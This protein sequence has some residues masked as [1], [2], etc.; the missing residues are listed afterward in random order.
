MLCVRITSPGPSF[1]VAQFGLERRSVKP[2]VAG[3]NPV[4]GGSAGMV[5][6]CKTLH[7]LWRDRR[8]TR[9]ASKRLTVWSNGNDTRLSPWRCGFN[10]Y[11]RCCSI[12]QTMKLGLLLTWKVILVGAKVC[13][14]NSSSIQL[15]VRLSCL[16]LPCGVTVALQPPNLEIRVQLPA[17]DTVVGC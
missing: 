2:Q 15:G 9:R 16:P 5:Q 6:R 17:R 7:L 10:S 14:E 12:L 13:L 11:Y 4:V 3:S 8:S 1:D